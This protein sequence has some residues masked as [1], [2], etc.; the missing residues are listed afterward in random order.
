M[1]AYCIRRVGVRVFHF[2]VFPFAVKFIGAD[3][4]FAG[5]KGQDK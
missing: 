3:S 2:D 4:G 5:G 1:L